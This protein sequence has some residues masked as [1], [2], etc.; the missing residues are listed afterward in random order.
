MKYINF[1]YSLLF[2]LRYLPIKQALKVPILISFKVK[3][4][5]H[6]GSIVIDSPN[7]YRYMITF[8]YKGYSLIPSAKSLL[9]IENGGKLVIKGK[10]VFAQGHRIWI[11]SNKKIVVGSNFYCNRNC[12][13]RCSDNITFGNDVLIGWNVSFNTT[14]GHYLVENDIKHINHGTINIG[15]SVWIAADSK[16]QKNSGVFDFSVV[17]QSSLVTKIFTMPNSLLGGVPAKLLRTNISWKI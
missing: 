2:C 12:I 1:L 16:F 7:I 10:A 6:R 9:S 15:N 5:L 3:T 14:D 17:A 8:G 13:F 11:Q 4:K